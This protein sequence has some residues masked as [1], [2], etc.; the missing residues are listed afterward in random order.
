MSR[1]RT[2]TFRPSLITGIL[3]LLIRSSK[4]RSDRGKKDGIAF[5][6]IYVGGMTIG[7]DYSRRPL[8]N[9]FLLGSGQPDRLPYGVG[10][11]KGRNGFER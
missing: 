8:G 2:I 9:L 3:P 6:G 1:A 11:L 4:T 5:R 10:Q 7:S